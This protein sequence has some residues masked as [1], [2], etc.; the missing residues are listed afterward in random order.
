MGMTDAGRSPGFWIVV[1][2]LAV[3][4]V[5]MLVGQT[6]GVFNYDLAARMG[7]QEK[8]EEMTDFGVQVNRAFG[9]ADTVVYVPL[10][11]ISLVGLI[12]RKRW[13][14]LVTAAFF[15]A[16]AYWTATVTFMLLFLPG[17]AGYSNVP[18]P[19]IWLFIGTYMVAGVAGLLYIV[20]RG[21]E[22]LR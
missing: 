19:E 7:L 14:L 16:S 13:S 2:F 1:V 11:L 9:A 6:V 10:M 5:L 17:V 22:L 20:W 21:E 8:P 4:I 15:G 12:L 3:S 18:G